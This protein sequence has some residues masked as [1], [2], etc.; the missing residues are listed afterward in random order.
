MPVAGPSLGTASALL[1]AAAVLVGVGECFYTTALMP[2]VADLAPSSVRGRYVA[3]MGFSW[4]IGLIIAPT[5][6]GEPLSVSAAALFIGSAVE[7]LA[8]AAAILAVERHLP[9]AACLTP[10]PV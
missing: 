6:G 2:L 1:L 7:A 10:Q 4:W 3:A 8:A 5:V 9:T